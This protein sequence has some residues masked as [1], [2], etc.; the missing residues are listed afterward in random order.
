M[1]EAVPKG[2]RVRNLNSMWTQKYSFPFTFQQLINQVLT[3][4]VKKK[5]IIIIIYIKKK[6]EKKERKD[7]YIYIYMYIYI[8][9][10]YNFMT[11]YAKAM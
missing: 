4:L 8:K 11:L 2:G 5:K 1:S 6:E 9:D 3:S 10:E 7:I